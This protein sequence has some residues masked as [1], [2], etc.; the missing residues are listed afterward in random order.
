MSVF[1]VSEYRYSYIATKYVFI[2]E[3]AN[4]WKDADTFVTI[5]WRLEAVAY[6]KELILLVAW[7]DNP[8]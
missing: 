7:H 2:A 5:N 3:S 4:N 6:D 1:H 8:Y